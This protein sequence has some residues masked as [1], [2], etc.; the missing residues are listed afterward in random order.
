MYNI[1]W[2]VYK[3]QGFIFPNVDGPGGKRFFPFL[4]GEGREREGAHHVNVKGAFT[5]C[6]DS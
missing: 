1:H 2:H 3:Y 4:G 6:W 5:V